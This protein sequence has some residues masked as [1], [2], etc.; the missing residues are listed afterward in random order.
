MEGDTRYVD[1]ITSFC[2]WG[3]TS[4]IRVDK[5]FP[6]IA[7][8]FYVTG[9]P[10]HDKRCIKL[11]TKNISNS[12]A[13]IGLITRQ[14]MLND[15]LK[16]RP[17]ESIVKN[18]SKSK[19]IYDY[20]NKITN[21][22]LLSQDN[23][24]VDEI[25]IE[26][27]DIKT[28]LQLILKL[29]EEAHEI[30]LKVHPREDKELWIDFA[31]KYKLN[32]KL[33]HWSIPFSHWIKNL[34]YVIGPSSTSFY[35]CCIA[36]VH[37]ICTRRINKIRDLHIKESSEEYGAL[38]KYIDTPDSIDD[39]VNI[40][41]KKNRNFELNEGIKTILSKETNYPDS[42]NSIDKI[43]EV[44]LSSKKEDLVSPLMKKIYM[45]GFHLYGNFVINLKIGIYRFLNRKVE[46]GSTFLMSKKNRK[47]I[48]SLVD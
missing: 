28:L 15:F 40:V 42:I 26:A 20:N 24:P 39:I 3:E 8:K 27:V 37:P 1:K 33:A 43:V 11:K 25:F 5:Y 23:E 16:R 30:Y 10:R 41:G 4:K 44:T 34:D 45:I 47:Y 19:T 17:I 13:K 7:H 18:Y 38:M 29:N 36:G 9:H 46:Q 2:L 32:V 48:D 21:D 31:R 14:P 35:D 22:F 12:K 6:K